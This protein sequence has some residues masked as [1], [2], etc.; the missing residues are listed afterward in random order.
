MVQFGLYGGLAH[1]AGPAE[2]GA[3]GGY[4][5]GLSPSPVPDAAA[6]WGVGQAEFRSGIL[7][8]PVSWDEIG[9][10]T[11]WTEKPAD[12]MGLEPG[13]FV[14]YT[15]NHA[16]SAQI[17]PWLHITFRRKARFATV[18]PIAWDAGRLEMYTRRFAI[19]H[20]FGVAPV[21]LDGLAA[22]GHDPIAVMQRIGRISAQ[23]GAWERLDSAGLKPSRL[24]WIGPLLVFDPC[25]GSGGR[26]DN[27]QWDLE[28][29]DGEIVLTSGPNRTARFERVPTGVRGRIA[30]VDGEPRLFVG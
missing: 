25:D 29:V 7:P 22:A 26:F 8:L 4:L 5:R 18:M 13:Q 1:D 17:W 20:L 21:M 15:L 30:G 28:S 24:T 11:E 19:D 3:L 2:I 6:L 12:L 14:L 10:D 9:R 16:Q 27:S 23:P